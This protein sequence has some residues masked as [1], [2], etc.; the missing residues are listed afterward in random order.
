MSPPAAVAGPLAEPAAE[1]AGRD[2]ED[3]RHQ[4][5]GGE[6][7]AGLQRPSSPRPRSGRGR[8]RAAS[9]RSRRRRPPRRGWRAAKERTR[10]SG[11]SITGAVVAGASATTKQRRGRAPRRRSAATH[12]R[13]APAPVGAL[14]D[15]RAV[16]RAIAGGEQR[17]RRAASGAAVLRLADLVAGRARPAITATIPIG[18]VDEED[19]APARAS[20]SRPPIGGPSAAATPP[21]ADQMP[22]ATARCSAGK[23]GRIR[24]R[25]L[26]HASSPRRP[27]AGR[28]RR[29]GRRPRGRAR[30]APSRR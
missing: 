20:T 30:R 22:T 11:S 12:A 4:R 25:V 6:G 13:V 26:G 17:R 29:P 2:R 1:P 18:H 21:T 3:R 5:A 8:R 14:D 24:P 28:A 9:P 23:A 7:E 15:R 16:S 10:S 27:P 19:P